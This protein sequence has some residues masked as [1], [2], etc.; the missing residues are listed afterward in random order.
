MNPYPFSG[1]FES[2]D[3]DEAMSDDQT[4]EE[5]VRSGFLGIC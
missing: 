1:G 2:D 3:S 4:I 5:M